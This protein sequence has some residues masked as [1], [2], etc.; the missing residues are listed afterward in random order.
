MQRP[1]L[2]LASRKGRRA[3]ALALIL[4][5]S[6]KCGFHAETRTNRSSEG[7][8]PRSQSDMSF[9]LYQ[10]SPG[11]AEPV[12]P[13]PLLL[14]VRLSSL[15]TGP[16]EDIPAPIGIES[17]APPTCAHIWS[18]S[19]CEDG[20]KGKTGTSCPETCMSCANCNPAPV[21]ITRRMLISTG[22]RFAD[23]SE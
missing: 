1:P 12:L 7:M 10:D 14:V 17:L 21:R 20:G 22:A 13:P 5:G 18:K 16:C 6:F 9:P 3:L 15:Q 11:E 19:A 23:P 4:H 8:S 2:R